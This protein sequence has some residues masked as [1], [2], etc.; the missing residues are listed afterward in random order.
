V[1]LIILHDETQNAAPEWVS[2]IKYCLHL[3]IIGC[4]LEKIL[5]LITENNQLLRAL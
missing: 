1:A 2:P 4:L 3:P 5:D